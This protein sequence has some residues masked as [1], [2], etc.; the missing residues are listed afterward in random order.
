VFWSIITNRILDNN[1][2]GDQIDKIGGLVGEARL[3]RDDA[4]YLAAVKLRIRVNRSQGRAEDVIQVAN[5]ITSNAQYS[6][7]AVASFLLQTYN[8]DGST[9]ETLLRLLG[10]TKL[11][12]SRGFVWYSTWP[13]NYDATYQ[14]NWVPASRYSTFPTWTINALFAPV[15]VSSRS[16]IGFPCPNRPVAAALISGA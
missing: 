7:P 15:M 16:R 14:Q 1:P 4:P 2:T 11:G 12:G 13:V 5:L 9:V 3:G 10:Q 6:E 8:I